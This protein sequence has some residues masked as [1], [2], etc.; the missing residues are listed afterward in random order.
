MIRPFCLTQS[1]NAQILFQVHIFK[2]IP[3]LQKAVTNVTAN[4]K[5]GMFK[6]SKA[7]Y[8]AWL[9]LGNAYRID[10]QLENAVQCYQKYLSLQKKGQYVII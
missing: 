1:F 6:E 2:S 5:E 7:P 8:D 9:Y 10:N 4:Y 3:F